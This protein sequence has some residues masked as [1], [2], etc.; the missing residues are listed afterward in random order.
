MSKKKNSTPYLAEVYETTC[1]KTKQLREAGYTVV[2]KWECDFEEQKK[3]DP[4]LLC[5]I[6]PAFW[7]KKSTWR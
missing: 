3:T 5:S 1:K 2:E 7:K 6:H 4:S